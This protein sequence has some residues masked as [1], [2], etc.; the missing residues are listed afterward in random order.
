MSEVSEIDL[1]QNY[2]LD[3]KGNS[4]HKDDGNQNETSD[5]NNR[6]KLSKKQ[7]KRKMKEAQWEI[8]KKLKKENDKIKKKLKREQ[9]KQNTTNNNTNFSSSSQK[10][11]TTKDNTHTEINSTPAAV[12]LRNKSINK[13]EYLVQC[14][15]NF[16]VIIDCAFEE[17]HNEKSMKSVG[18]QILFCYG[19]NRHSISPVHLSLTGK[20]CRISACILYSVCVYIHFYTLS[21]F[22]MFAV[23]VAI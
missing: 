21:T 12:K 18:Q 11:D 19:L 1:D 7:M 22:I 5:H 2:V 13:H 15:Q 16:S 9:N 6:P 10:D 4:S 14:N 3:V 8:N 23:H 17:Y 20:V